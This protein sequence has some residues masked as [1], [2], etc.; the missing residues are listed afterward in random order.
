MGHHCRGIHDKPVA[1]VN[2]EKSGPFTITGIRFS[3]SPFN[4]VPTL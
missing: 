1:A 3:Y 4:F 2:H